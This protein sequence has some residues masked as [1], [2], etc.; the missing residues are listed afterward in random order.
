MFS[1]KPTPTQPVT[2]THT[3]HSNPGRTPMNHNQ[4]NEI[5]IAGLSNNDK[6]RQSKSVIDEWLTMRGDLESEGDI[7]IKGK[8]IGNVLCKMLILDE[9]AIVE[10]GIIADE[11]V[12]RGTTRGGA[13]QAKRVLLQSTARVAS[14]IIH[15]KFSAEEGARI[16]GKLSLLDATTAKTAETKPAAK[17]TA[18]AVGPNIET[19]PAAAKKNGTAEIGNGRLTQN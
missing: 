11:V 2:T 12:I 15:E 16:E 8:V 14:E 13:V 10:G 6:A 7:L 4:D 5:S 3:T 1:K 19:M 18:K 9:D 17:K